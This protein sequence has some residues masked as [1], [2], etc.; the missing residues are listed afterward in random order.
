M[1]KKGIIYFHQGWT[2]IINLLSLINY[3]N[4][5]YQLIYILMRE[6]AKNLIDFYTKDM[7]NVEIIYISKWELDYRGMSASTRTEASFWGTRL[8]KYKD[9]CD[10]LFHGC[11]DFLR[12]D[13]YKKSF[14]HCVNFVKKFYISYDIPYI[15]RVNL[16]NINRNYELENEMYEK[17][18]EKHGKEYIL[19]HEEIR[20]YD[21]N[22]QIINLNGISNT[23]FDMIKILEEAI[24]LHLKDSIWGAITYLLD[25]KY[26][27]FKNKKIFIYTKRNYK[28]MF[29]EPVKLNNWTIINI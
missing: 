13:K 24:E 2:D 15:T 27:M 17:F 4:S 26:N 12:E 1:K 14:R 3:Y 6:D 20:N 10:I 8:K 25:A 29:T 16:F 18:I 28:D 22:K 5:K 21:T 9:E 11:H 7:Q 23:F 19:Y